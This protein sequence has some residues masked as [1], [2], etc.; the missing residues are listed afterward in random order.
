M[1][2]R[3]LHADAFFQLFQTH[4]PQFWPLRKKNK[5]NQELRFQDYLHTRNLINVPGESRIKSQLPF[6]CETG[7][8]SIDFVLLPSPFSGKN[9]HISEVLATCEL[10]GP[11]RKTLWEFKPNWYNRNHGK[12]GLLPD[13]KKQYARACRYPAVEHYCAWVVTLNDCNS[14]LRR[15]FHSSLDTLRKGVHLDLGAAEGAVVTCRSCH[16]EQIVPD[17]IVMFLWEVKDVGS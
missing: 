3:G 14:K 9:P 8:Q 16:F 1:N 4:W 13:V 7:L 5:R 17:E 12:Y 15:D 10:K 2:S 11:A 6:N